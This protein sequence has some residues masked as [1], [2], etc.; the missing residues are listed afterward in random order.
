[1]PRIRNRSKRITR[2]KPRSKRITRKKPRSKRITRKKP[3]YKRIRVMRGGGDRIRRMFN[4]VFGNS[5]LAP[6]DV[7][8]QGAN[9][10]ISGERD[11]AAA[12][13]YAANAVITEK[14]DGKYAS[15][16]WERTP[17]NSTNYPGSYYIPSV[18]KE[19]AVWGAG[20][21]AGQPTGP[22]ADIGGGYDIDAVINGELIRICNALVTWK[23]I[24]RSGSLLTG[25]PV[26]D[27][28]TGEGFTFDK[29]RAN[30]ELKLQLLEPRWRD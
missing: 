3:R 6:Y 11:A 18:V 26:D 2:T 15:L 27:Y 29:C 24:R 16:L 21:K 30:I 4:S 13:T 20:L 25:K 10:A 1:M 17:C 5:V 28:L 22:L 12:A 7:E 23:G 14:R 8:I 19:L 9:V